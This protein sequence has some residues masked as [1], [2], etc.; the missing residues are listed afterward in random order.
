M[1]LHTSLT[2]PEVRTVLRR[3]QAK[4]LITPDVH[5]AVWTAGRSLTH[6]HG[7]DIQLG[8]HD[9]DSLPAGYK[10]QRGTNMRLRRTR[11]SS[12]G[13]ARYAATWHEWGWLIAEIFAADPRSR[14]G[15]NPARSRHPWGYFTPAD[16]HAKTGSQFRPAP[17]PRYTTDPM[18]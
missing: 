12:G 8:T 5:F 11:H 10:D 18:F 15:A 2:A 17:A 16:F 7:Y 13:G 9:R 3:A 1:R 14:W 6:P 4:G